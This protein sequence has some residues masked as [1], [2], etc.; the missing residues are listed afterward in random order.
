M[1][2]LVPVITR[3]KRSAGFF[4]TT[5]SQHPTF[6]VYLSQSTAR[7]LEFLLLDEADNVLHQERIAIEGSSQILRI[8]LGKNS[9]PL[10]VG[11]T[12]NWVLVKLCDEEDPSRNP[13]VEGLIQRVEP[14]APLTQRLKKANLLGRARLYAEAGIWFEALAAMA[15]LR[16]QNPTSLSVAADWSGLLKAI[17]LAQIPYLG[18]LAEEEKI[19]Q[20]PL[21]HCPAKK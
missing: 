6:W 17:D 20:V 7:Q 19:D 10:E 3:P 4:G 21:T 9:P 14:G 18:K 8:K 2:P 15:E 13:F 16:C 11:K 1:I 12:Y 5:I